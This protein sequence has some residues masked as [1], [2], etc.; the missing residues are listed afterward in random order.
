VDGVL[1]HYKE[2]TALPGIA[3]PANSEPPGE[4]GEG[5]QP[6]APAS[7]VHARAA[8]NGRASTS[9]TSQEP[10]VVL[11]LHG[12]NG[13][14]YNFRGVMARIAQGVAASG[15]ACRVIAFDRP[16]F[17][18]SGRPLNWDKEEDNPYTQVWRRV[19]VL[20]LCKLCCC[21]AG[22]HRGRGGWQAVT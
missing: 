6:L 2:V 19:A 16:P 11:L 18:L 14:E 13:S 15:R 17:G 3:P 12:F 21:L 8:S 4:D 10:L 5:V 20:K 22:R 9:A 7:I 1:I